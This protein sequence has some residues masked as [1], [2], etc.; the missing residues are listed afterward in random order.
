MLVV[1]DIL[2]NKKIATVAM[3]PQNEQAKV[4]KAI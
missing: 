4:N 2:R 1:K 3:K